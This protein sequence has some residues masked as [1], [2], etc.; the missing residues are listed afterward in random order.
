MKK[1][2]T[3]IAVPLVLSLAGCSISST[4]TEQK[5][6]VAF[7]TNINKN[8]T[9]QSYPDFQFYRDIESL[10]LGKQYKKTDSDGNKIYLSVTD[11]NTI[12]GIEKESRVFEDINDCRTAYNKDRAILDGNSLDTTD[13]D[14][15]DSLNVMGSSK[16]YSVEYTPCVKHGMDQSNYSIYVH[17]N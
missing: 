6:F 9:S 10:Y 7:G 3:L 15:E 17:K 1:I 13:S 11:K 5:D 4:K 14:K 2:L 16:Q 12:K 8:Y